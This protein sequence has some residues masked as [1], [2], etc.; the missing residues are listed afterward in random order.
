MKKAYSVAG[1]V[2]LVELALQF[3]LI[4]AG[5]LSV[6]GA[7]SNKDTAASVFSGFK[8]GDNFAVLHAL[9]GTLVIPFTILVLIALSFAAGHAGR[10]KGQTAAL[11]GL[12]VIQFFLG[13]AG[14]AGGTVAAAI[15]GLHG[16]NALVL[17][18]TAVTVVR[19][20]WAFGPAQAAEMAAAPAVSTSA[21]ETER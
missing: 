1:V 19:R 8:T 3:Y 6:W 17:V 2:L 12:I 11:F 7:D 15:G 10:V 14:G 5:A 4:A 18:G 9:N 16:L 20:T 13:I 21:L